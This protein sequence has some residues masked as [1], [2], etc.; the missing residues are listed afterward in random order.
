MPKGD[1]SITMPNVVRPCMQSKGDDNMQSPTSSEWVCCPRAM[2]VCQ[3][4]CYWT[5][6]MLF[7]RDDGLPRP[8]SSTVCFG[9]GP[10]WNASPYVLQQ[11]MLSKCDDAIPH[12]S[13]P[14][15]S[16]VEGQRWHVTPDV[17]RPLVLPNGDDGI[18]RTISSHHVCC[19][20]AIMASHS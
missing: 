2:M 1:Y 10:G 14:T 17:I 19:T 9:Q 7:K 3:A 12:R 5:L 6:S 18:E 4:Q 15:V 16:A 8:T 13:R 20:M 11:Y